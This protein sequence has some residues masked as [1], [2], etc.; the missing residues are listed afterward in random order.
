MSVSKV[1]QIFSLI[2]KPASSGIAEGRVCLV[3]AQKD[4]LKF[5]EG[6]VL[7]AQFTDPTYTPLMLMAAA[8]V[9]DVGSKLSHAAIVSREIG[10]PAVVGTALATKK[11]H[12]GDL[13]LVDGGQG[14][15]TIVKKSK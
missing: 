13:V 1:E 5:K 9:T 3:L 8:V 12:D 2:G 15:V 14:V 4:Y 7:V 6:D 11:L 10:I